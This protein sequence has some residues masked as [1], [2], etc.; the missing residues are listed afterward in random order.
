[1]L[2]SND[3]SFSCGGRRVVVAWRSD[4]V[5]VSISEVNLRRA[6]LVL[7]WVTVYRD[8]S[9]PGAGHLSRYVT[10]HLGQF[11]LAILSWVG[12]MSTSAKWH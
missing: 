11:S 8:R 1:M 7:G 12:T 6:R 3:Y 10:D 4:S 9:I 5:L 2:Y